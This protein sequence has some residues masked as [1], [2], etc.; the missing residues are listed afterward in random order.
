LS[1]R[2]RSFRD[3]F[4]PDLSLPGE[5]MVLKVGKKS[6]LAARFAQ[7]EQSQIYERS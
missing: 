6:P 7:I 2:P 1:P 3:R 5:V 4:A